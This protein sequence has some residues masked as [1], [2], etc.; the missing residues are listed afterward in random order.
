MIRKIILML[1]VFGVMVQGG[2]AEIWMV[3][4]DMAGG[5]FNG[6]MGVTELNTIT[7]PIEYI[8]TPGYVYMIA[9]GTCISG[10]F[11]DGGSQLAEIVL[12]GVVSNTAPSSSKVVNL[13]TPSTGKIS[14]NNAITINSGGSLS[15][16]T[17]RVI[18]SATAGLHVEMSRAGS[19]VIVS[20]ESPNIA[21]GS[22]CDGLGTFD[23]FMNGS[24]VYT[25]ED[26]GN[27]SFSI[28]DGVEYNIE[29]KKGNIS[30]WHNFTASG[31]DDWS[32]ICTE[33]NPALGV[34]TGP[35]AN[36]GFMT[37][38]MTGNGMFKV[39]QG[40]ELW[41]NSPNAVSAS[42][43]SL[44]DGVPMQ[45]FFSNSTIAGAWWNFTID[46][47]FDAIWY[48][49]GCG[50]G[51]S[52]ITGTLTD[53]Y[54]DGMFGI[55]LAIYEGTNLSGGPITDSSGTFNAA[56][57]LPSTNY[58]VYVRGFGADSADHFIGVFNTDA[59]G[60]NWDISQ[61][62][63]LNP[64]VEVNVRVDGNYT[65]PYSVLIIDH[66]GPTANISTQRD[67]TSAAFGKY[68][69]P[70]II[71]WNDATFR[72]TALNFTE[73][74][75]YSFSN[76][77]DTAPGQ[78]CTDD[79]CI[80]DIHINTTIPAPPIW[81]EEAN[82]TKDFNLTGYLRGLDRGVG[83][84][85]IPDQHVTIDCTGGSFGT[86]TFNSSTG[87]FDVDINESQCQDITYTA[88]AYETK[89]FYD[90]NWTEWDNEFVYLERLDTSCIVPTLHNTRNPSRIG[91]TIEFSS[92][93]PI[94]SPSYPSNHRVLIND[95]DGVELYNSGVVVGFANHTFQFL[96][97]GFFTIIIENTN[98]LITQHVLGN[99]GD[100]NSMEVSP[101]VVNKF[102]GYFDIIYYSNSSFN[103]I[104]VSQ[105]GTSV[106]SFNTDYRVLTTQ[107]INKGAFASFSSGDV[108]DIYF[109]NG[110]QTIITK[111]IT[112]S[113]GTVDQPCGLPNCKEIVTSTSS[114]YQDLSYSSMVEKLFNNKVII[115]IMI[116]LSILI[117]IGRYYI[118]IF[119]V[120]LTY[121]YE[122]NLIP[123]I[124]FF[125]I[126]TILILVFAYK[127]TNVGGNAE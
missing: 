47:S 32:P 108:I 52:N 116:L 8:N 86:S 54:G 93:M 12:T 113:G 92:C 90:V 101:L 48:I 67:I 123:N 27:Y 10:C 59:D 94:G 45:V 97:E 72:V 115:A 112:L 105:N 25:D 51:Q 100:L 44:L 124:I 76:L 50:G 118:T 26:D 82:L 33:C 87:R 19:T 9:G 109:M 125:S 7:I 103:H 3:S 58:N 70:V 11:Y 38:D 29:Y 53:E 89:K 111:F 91:Q 28:F 99:D 40:G 56:T 107:R 60:F 127:I 4:S 55:Q 74:F 117:Y 66:E 49:E 23:I 63:G 17:S 57:L 37:L 64:S 14:F 46:S 69:Y 85:A 119:G 106:L 18:R 79:R 34:L 121:A 31:N 65:T 114:S 126:V 81:G 41:F 16:L 96:D 102:L 95:I 77:R 30:E 5:F 88:P 43:S 104:N 21:Q 42:I 20:T 84:W 73:D 68:T 120:W 110:N 39:Y 122:T 36:P 83:F 75:D 24:F 35:T 2:S 98:Q 15:V 71:N 22:S 62:T 6:T 13:R 61:Y 1:L 78:E 80:I